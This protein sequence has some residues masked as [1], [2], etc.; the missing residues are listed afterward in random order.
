MKSEKFAT[1]A[2]ANSWRTSAVANFSLSFFTYTLYACT[3]LITRRKL[4]PQII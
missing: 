2:V 1:A 4:P 3:C